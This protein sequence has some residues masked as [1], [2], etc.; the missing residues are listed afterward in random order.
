[1]STTLA[2]SPMRSTPARGMV[3][4]AP[5]SEKET[6]MQQIQV[7]TRPHPRHTTPAEPPTVNRKI[8]R[9]WFSESPPQAMRKS[10]R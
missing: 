5:A 2:I 6:T 10:G 7:T 1:V 8:A 9:L 3:K 4:A